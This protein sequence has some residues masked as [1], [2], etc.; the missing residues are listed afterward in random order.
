MHMQDLP[1]TIE[2]LGQPLVM[3]SSNQDLLESASST[4]STANATI[5]SSTVDLLAPD[6][7]GDDPGDHSLEV[8][9][10]QSQ[11]VSVQPG[12][13]GLSSDSLQVCGV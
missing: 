9:D 7:L 5:T 1:V 2:S 4:T 10:I 6:S 13:E 12:I 3:S 8:N 11:L